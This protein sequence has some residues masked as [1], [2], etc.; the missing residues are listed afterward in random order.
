MTSLAPELRG[1]AAVRAGVA[2]FLRAAL[3]VHLEACR[4]AWGLSEAQLPAPVSNPTEDPLLGPDAYFARPIDTIDRWPMVSVTHG[5]ATRAR[6][7]GSVDFNDDGDPVTTT[8]YPMRVYSW[9]RA[10]GRD[11]VIDMRDNFIAAVQV[12]L[13]SHVDLGTNGWLRLDPRSLAVDFSEVDKVKGER[14]V[15]GAYVGFDLSATETLTDRLALPE[16]YP[17][18]TVSGVNASGTPLPPPT[19]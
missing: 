13:A 18:D 6:A 2:G 7:R 1:P 10:V 8:V 12:A 15:A 11:E 16:G 17:R 19:Q 9:V 5:R 4:G 3:P 14:W